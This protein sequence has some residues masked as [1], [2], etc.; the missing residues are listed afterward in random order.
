MSGEDSGTNLLVGKEKHVPCGCLEG[1]N[2]LQEESASAQVEKMVFEMTEWKTNRKWFQ[3]E[4]IIRS[5]D[6]PGR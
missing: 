6:G 5:K 4:K 1:G 2:F 3:K